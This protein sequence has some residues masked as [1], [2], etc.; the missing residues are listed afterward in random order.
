MTIYLR[1]R[2][3]QK[4]SL[5]FPKTIGLKIEKN[6]KKI[7]TLKI[8]RMSTQD[9]SQVTMKGGQ[10]RKLQKKQFSLLKKGTQ[11]HK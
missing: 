10:S 6:T 11:N 1:K 8:H 5:L 4:T 9:N 3:K 2:T 7:L